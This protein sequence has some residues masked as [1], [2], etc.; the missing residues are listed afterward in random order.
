MKVKKIILL[1][2]I[3]V[4]LT[5]LMSTK[6]EKDDPDNPTTCEGI[7]SATA[8]GYVNADFCFDALVTYE[9]ND[10]QDL[11]FTVRQDG[12]PIYSCT[13]DIA[14][15]DGP[16]TYNFAV[17][18]P[19]YIELVVHGDE[20]EFYK[21]QSGSITISQV[22]AANFVASFNAV[23]LGYYNEQTVNFSGSVNFSGV[24]N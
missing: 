14:V 1:L 10:N 3:A 13:I 16:G 15:L 7:V 5:L 23:T 2:S 18:S 8:S 4:G 9:N 22:D 11:Y 19:Y 20:N 6:C 24:V 21:G 17:D 12:E